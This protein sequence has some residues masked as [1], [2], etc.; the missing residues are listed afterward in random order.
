MKGSR[1][2]AC[3]AGL[4]SLATLVAT[5]AAGAAAA[6]GFAAFFFV[7]GF[8]RGWRCRSMYL[9]SRLGCACSG[10]LRRARRRWFA[11]WRRCGLRCSRCFA[12]P[13][14]RRRGLWRRLRPDR[15]A[16]QREH[17]DSRVYLHMCL[18]LRRRLC[19]WG[20]SGSIVVTV[21]S[22]RGTGGHYALVRRVVIF[23][24]RALLDPLIAPNPS[25]F[26]LTMRSSLAVR[27]KKFS[28]E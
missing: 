7:V 24:G 14:S 15:T 16:S 2:L 18:L 3:V 4:A 13:R 28:I 8:G 10:R 12:R 23:S 9:Q 19:S 5:F 25:P 1:L 6:A 26:T 22:A 11:R 27:S 20:R 17:E 21:E